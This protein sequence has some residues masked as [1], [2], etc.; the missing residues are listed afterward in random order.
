MSLGYSL[1]SINKCMF[2]D[3]GRT[4][5]VRT[6][7]RKPCGDPPQLRGRIPL[8]HVVTLY[9]ILSN[10]EQRSDA[11]LTYK[12]IHGVMDG[13]W[14][15]Q[16]YRIPYQDSSAAH[17]C[18]FRRV[19]KLAAN[20]FAGDNAADYLCGVR[21]HITL[22][23]YDALRGSTG[24]Y[25]WEMCMSR[26]VSELRTGT[27][28]VFVNNWT[29]I[30]FSSILGV[31][32]WMEPITLDN[33]HDMYVCVDVDWYSARVSALRPLADETIYP[34][35]QPDPEK[36]ESDN[37]YFEMESGRTGPTMVNLASSPYLIAESG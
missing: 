24:S 31:N 32:K 36:H 7:H 3:G 20:I 17:R 34:Q 23:K 37:F 27:E 35:I 33:L 5:Q 22:F 16:I 8:V 9:M 13:V 21:P 11:T 29:E 15:R 26:P 2:A 30:E 10:G 12:N 1:H 18:Y 28:I 19:D 6:L 14:Y 25:Y 4:G